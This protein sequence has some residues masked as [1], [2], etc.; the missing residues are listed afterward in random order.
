M[1]KEV[2]LELFDVID[3]LE[4]R[5]VDYTTAGTKNV[6]AGWIGINFIVVVIFLLCYVALSNHRRVPC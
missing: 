2:D 3:F 1:K 5:G 6:S 4:D